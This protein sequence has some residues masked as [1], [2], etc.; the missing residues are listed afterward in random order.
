MEILDRICY[1]CIDILRYWEA[2][3]GI[4]Y[5]VINTVLFV[6]IQPMLILFF[7]ITT[8]ICSKINNFKVKR[9]INYLTIFILFGCTVGTIL[10][11]LIPLLKQ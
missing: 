5:G 11:V 9:N 8:L 1:I 4:P 6:I 10:L 3:T 2:Y 7:A